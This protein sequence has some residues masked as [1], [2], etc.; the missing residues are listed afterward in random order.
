MGRFFAHQTEMFARF[1]RRQIWRAQRVSRLLPAAVAR[2][3]GLG[4]TARKAIQIL[5]SQGLP[6]L[7]IRLRFLETV[8]GQIADTNPAADE[9]D[10]GDWHIVRH[11]VDPRLDVEAPS[12]PAGVSAINVGLFGVADATGLAPASIGHCLA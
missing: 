9:G 5:Y 3:G 6:G 11:Y 7:R 12:C 2:T 1:L 4:A 10:A 8:C